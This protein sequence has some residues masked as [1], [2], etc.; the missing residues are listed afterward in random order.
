MKVWDGGEPGSFGSMSFEEWGQVTAARV[1][2][3][4]V[5]KATA[6]RLG[7]EEFDATVGQPTESPDSDG[8]VIWLKVETV[9]DEEG[10][11]RSTPTVSIT[12]VADAGPRSAEVTVSLEGDP[13]R[14][15]SLSSPVQW[16]NNWFRRNFNRRMCRSG[17]ML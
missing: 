14:G 1:G 15:Q 16:R 12:E 4:P 10:D 9:L 17:R 8:P 7:T 6:T 11:V 5:R 3:E 13:I 2:L